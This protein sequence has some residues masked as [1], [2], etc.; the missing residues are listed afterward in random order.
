MNN[1]KDLIAK[2]RD[3]IKKE[4]FLSLLDLYKSNVRDMETGGQLA[5]RA[6]WKVNKIEDE[7]IRRY[8]TGYFDG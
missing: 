4:K 8:R 5:D 7:F 6:F 1:L 3:K 2:A